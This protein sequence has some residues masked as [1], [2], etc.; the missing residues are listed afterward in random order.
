MAFYWGGGGGGGE[1][2]GNPEKTMLMVDKNQYVHIQCTSFI[3][4]LDKV[5]SSGQK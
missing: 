2:S 3:F 4:R 5:S 1:G